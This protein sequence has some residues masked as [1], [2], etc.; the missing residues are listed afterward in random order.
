MVTPIISLT[1]GRSGNASPIEA[2]SKKNQ[3]DT[4]T[5]E[6][7]VANITAAPSQINI[8]DGSEEAKELLEASNGIGPG[9][10]EAK[11]SVEGRSVE[12]SNPI[13]YKTFS[14]IHDL[15]ETTATETEVVGAGNGT[16]MEPETKSWHMEMLLSLFMRSDERE[17]RHLAKR[18]GIKSSSLF[19]PAAAHQA[20]VVASN[21]GQKRP[22]FESSEEPSQLPI[23][24]HI[25]KDVG[26]TGESCNNKKDVANQF[27][28]KYKRQKYASRTL[29][30]MECAVMEQFAAKEKEIEPLCK[31]FTL[32]YNECSMSTLSSWAFQQ[33]TED[34]TARDMRKMN[35]YY[36]PAAAVSFRQCGM[37]RQFG[38][39]E[40]E[41]EELARR[42]ILSTDVVQKGL[43]VEQRVAKEVSIQ[44]SLRDFVMADQKNRGY[45]AYTQRKEKLFI[46]YPWIDVLT[47]EAQGS[48]DSGA[49]TNDAKGRDNTSGGQKKG[50]I[51]VDVVVRDHFLTGSSIDTPLATIV[52]KETGG[53]LEESEEDEGMSVAGRLSISTNHIMDTSMDTIDHTMD[54]SMDTSMT[55]PDEPTSSK[56]RGKSKGSK[57]TEIEA[58]EVCGSNHAL[59]DLLL[60]DGCDKLFHQQCLDPPLAKVPEGDWFC[61][62]CKSYDSDVSEVTIIE[63]LDDFVIEQ[64]KLKTVEKEVCEREKDVRVGFDSNPWTASLT[65][66]AAS[67]E[68]ADLDGETIENMSLHS[69]DEWE[70]KEHED[71]MFDTLS[72][73]TACNANIELGELC[74]AKRRGTH[75]SKKALARDFFWPAMVVHVHNNSI[76]FDGVLQTPYIVKFFSIPAGGRIRASHALPF[77]PHYEALGNRRLSSNQGK[78]KAWFNDFHTAMREAVDHVG[79]SSLE[80]AYRDSQRN[81]ED[82]LSSLPVKE[83]ESR[84]KMDQP[85]SKGKRKRAVQKQVSR[86]REWQN[87]AKMEIDGI[88]ILSIP[89][90]QDATITGAEEDSAASSVE[91]ED[92]GEMVDVL[93]PD[94]WSSDDTKFNLEDL[95]L[96]DNNPIEIHNL[97]GSLVVHYAKQS[98]E[99]QGSSTNIGIVAGFNKP[100]GKVLVRN[101]Q[102]IEDFIS[103]QHLQNKEGTRSFSTNLGSSEW[104]PMNELVHLTMGPSKGNS[105]FCRSAVNLTLEKTREQLLKFHARD[106]NHRELRMVELSSASEDDIYISDYAIF[107]EVGSGTSADAK[108]EDKTDCD[109]VNNCEDMVE[110]TNVVDSKKPL[111]DILDSES[112]VQLTQEV[113]KSS[114]KKEDT[115]ISKVVND[116]QEETIATDPQHNPGC[117]QDKMA[118]INTSKITDAVKGNPSTDDLS[119]RTVHS[120][121]SKLDDD[122]S[123]STDC[124]KLDKPSPNA[125][126]KVD[127]IEENK[128]DAKTKKG[129]YIEEGKSD[130]NA[131]QAVDSTK[132]KE[133]KDHAANIVVV[134]N[135]INV[136]EEHTSL[137]EH[138]SL[139]STVD[140]IATSK[141]GNEKNDGN[142]DAAS[143]MDCGDKVNT[144]DAN[145]DNQMTPTAETRSEKSSGESEPNFA[146]KSDAKTSEPAQPEAPLGDLEKGRTRGGTR[147]VPKRRSTRSPGPALS[148]KSSSSKKNDEPPSLKK[149]AKKN[150]APTKKPEPMSP[151]PTAA[152]AAAAAASPIATDDS[153]TRKGSGGDAGEIFQAERIIVDRKN[154]N[155]RE[156]LIKWKGFSDEHNT[157]ENEKNILDPLFLKKYLCRKHI[158]ILKATPEAA[159]PKSPTARAIKALRKGIETMDDDPPVNSA[160]RT[161]P[162]CLKVLNDGAKKFG[163]HVRTHIQE[164]NY[165]QLKDIGRIVVLNWFK[166]K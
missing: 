89:K 147:Q 161:C 24:Y 39:Y 30:Q 27:P 154:G 158:N 139:A 105:N 152:V 62:Q 80:E 70:S 98:L 136:N 53:E 79:F 110:S 5:V 100:F 101:L 60:C 92:N 157:W 54:T 165:A 3:E 148:S 138:A 34:H 37:C 140:T 52:R 95:L 9:P 145:A 45:N 14:G 106:A 84:V 8:S 71:P 69:S 126:K 130:G 99:E 33:A 149:A 119:E 160:S 97:I 73:L 155:K 42:H 109:G 13:D 28:A 156:Y 35:F 163:G 82:A 23:L 46:S 133:A 32:L 88:S 118:N 10:L 153:P 85:V 66:A 15:T 107:N 102:N 31:P 150:N 43:Q 49:R 116:V 141:T 125:T 121:E 137:Q 96:A 51:E 21:S 114:E 117:D 103:Y 112:I 120:Q 132:T 74:W 19:T 164:P 129:D 16:K 135:G 123:P 36:Q 68:L 6:Q 78:G 93:T 142:T 22:R 131:P 81:A 12:G 61:E 25:L 17:L 1:G 18:S 48:T 76:A 67:A 144:N 166:D 108:D 29:P 7:T 75:T 50:S 104:I 57:E 134:V 162:V 38:H 55:K 2:P 64:R 20:E 72:D 83:T 59:E 128:S 159:N 146:H 41:C 44:K 127:D 11:Y 143:D 56:P 122:V 47:D 86:P 111:G 40:V 4:L 124:T 65:I 115:V 113:V 94:I 63:G 26:Q 151:P 87:T 58:C 91:V 77:F 90:H